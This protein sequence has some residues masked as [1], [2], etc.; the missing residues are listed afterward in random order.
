MWKV[1]LL[2]GTKINQIVHDSAGGGVLLPVMVMAVVF[3]V[4]CWPSEEEV[5]TLTEKHIHTGDSFSKFHWILQTSDS[6]SPS[7][8]SFFSRGCAW[9]PDLLQTLSRGLNSLFK[10]N[11][12][13]CFSLYLSVC[14]SQCFLLSC[15]IMLYLHVVRQNSHQETEDKCMRQQ[16][17]CNVRKRK[18]EGEGI[19]TE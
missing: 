16:L 17:H 7:T 14:I 10:H 9:A 6:P 3:T 19:E 1:A 15:C 11:N 13:K 8:N 2:P 4:R 18:R 12:I 5:W